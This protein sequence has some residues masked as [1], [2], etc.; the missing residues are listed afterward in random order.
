MQRIIRGLHNLPSQ[1]ITG[2]VATIGNFD[3]IHLGHQAVLSQLAMKADTLGLP[4]VIITFEPQPNEFFAPDKAPARL[5][6]FREKVEALCCYSIQQLCV[7][8]FDKK[9]ANMTAD[10][11]IERLLVQGLNVRYL[12]VGDDFKFGKDRQ[13]DFALLQQAGKQHGFQVVN[14]HTFAIEQKR[15]SSTRIRKALEAG[16]LIMAEKLLGRPF[17]MSGRVAHGDK[18]GRTMGFPTANIHLQR[19]KVPL[20]GVYAV[21]LFGIEGEPIQGVANIGVRPTVGAEKA[22]LE[23]HLF[24]FNREIYGEHVQVHFLHKLRDET[25]FDSLES[26]ITQ[27]KLDC[28]QAKRFFVTS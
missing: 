25:K 1:P 15:V 27:I 19:H 24:D 16:D 22:L 12:V 26:L 14:M 13:G 2:C 18:R 7:L 17:R 9:L 4:A 28:Q 8:R 10:T 6:R 23:V 21:Q 5:C 11:F 20:N 3:G